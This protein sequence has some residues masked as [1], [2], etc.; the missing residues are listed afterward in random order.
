MKG[1]QRVACFA[2]WWGGRLLGLRGE[3]RAKQSADET[4]EF[5]C[6]H[7]RLNRSVPVDQ[8]VFRTYRESGG[9]FSCLKVFQRGKEIYRLAD[10]S[11]TF[12]L[13]QPALTEYHV[14]KI[15]NGTD[16]TGR[17]RPDMIVTSWSGGAH[18]CFTRYI[19]E[20]QPKFRLL[21]KIEDGDGDLAHFADLDHDRHYVYVTTDWAFA[22]WRACFACSPAP[23]V[24]LRFIDDQNG[25]S[26]HVATDKMARAVPSPAKWQELVAKTRAAI[27]IYE[28]DDNPSPQG[29]FWGGMLDLMY[30]GHSDAAW[31][32]LDEAWPANKT[33]KDA[34]VRDFCS[35]LK[36]SQ[37]WPDLEKTVKELLHRRFVG[38]LRSREG[39]SSDG[40]QG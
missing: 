40:G 10:S 6:A 12:D 5:I 1:S 26:F 29:V 30:T 34:F 31:K 33:G 13:G 25:G 20:L 18:C 14:P 37:F 11:L 35:V 15:S 9:G 38:V 4:P 27:N 19:F 2:R 21:A 7:A 8:Y 3:A 16:L 36:S 28:P 39:A 17:G 24:I 32:L 23:D 22:Y